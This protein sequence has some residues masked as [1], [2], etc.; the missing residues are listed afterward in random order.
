MT[1]PPISSPLGGQKKRTEPRTH[2]N[3]AGQSG[4]GGWSGD[5]WSSLR[6]HINRTIMLHHRPLPPTTGQYSAVVE[7]LWVPESFM[8]SKEAEGQTNVGQ[9]AARP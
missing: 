1:S 8:V 5:D 6:K 3:S 2:S 9:I 7:L 4:G